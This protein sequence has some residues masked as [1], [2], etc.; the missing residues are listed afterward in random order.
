MERTDHAQAREKA[1]EA[2]SRRSRPELT[3]V[4]I[5]AADSGRILGDAVRSALDAGN[6]VE[7][8]VVDNASTDGEPERVATSHASDARF[9]LLR[10]DR[11]LGFG[12]ACNRG[13]AIASGDALLFQNPDCVIDRG[14]IEALRGISASEPSLGLVGIDVLTPDGI[15]ARGNRRR[16]P[17]LRRALTSMSGL[18]RFSNRCPALAGVEIEA[19]EARVSPDAPDGV[20]AVEHVDAVSGAC[21][22]LPRRVF[23]AIG[24]FDES[25]FLHVEDLD[26]CRRVR[27]AGFGV[28][29]APSLHAVHRQGTS[30]RHRPVFVSWHKHRSM[31]RYYETH[32]AS[33][34]A[35]LVSLLAWGGLWIHFA[36]LVPFEL[37][38]IGL[39]RIRG[40]KDASC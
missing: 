21:L 9:T 34:H 39:R 29:I 20:L 22:Y 17:T 26:L 33:S 10:N 27:S 14:T 36:L 18:S 3:S 15:S 23:D 28:A 24:G 32:E 37:A 25:Y 11:N 19:P 38:R 13:A 7:V 16:D 30:S 31:W 4:V 40:I 35:P 6:A 5:V 12:T 8:I 1:A 2:S